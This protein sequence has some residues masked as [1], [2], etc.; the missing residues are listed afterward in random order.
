MSFARVRDAGASAYQTPNDGSMTNDEH[1]LLYPLQLKDDRFQPDCLLA[2]VNSGQT[3]QLTTQ[4]V[5]RLCARGTMSIRI[6]QESF[7]FIRIS[8]HCLLG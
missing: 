7:P 5:I 4:V 1:V 6:S 8:L 2:E 3:T